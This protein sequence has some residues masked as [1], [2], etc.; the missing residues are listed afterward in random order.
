MKK[1]VTIFVILITMLFASACSSEEIK[2]NDEEAKEINLNKYVEVTFNGN[3]LAGY[4]SVS[5]DKEQFLLDNIDN[6]SFNKENEQVYKE[7]YGNVDK[8][9]A[10]EVLKYITVRLDKSN[11]L[12]NGDTVEIVWDINDEKIS[13]YF[14]FNYEFSSQT[15]TVAN[16]VDA[17]TFDPF[18]KIKLSYSGI[19]PYGEARVT[20]YEYGQ[21]G[22]YEITPN[23]NLKNGDT[24]KVSYLCED[25]S[26]MVQQFGTYPNCFEKEYIV[27]GLQSYVQSLEEVSSEQYEKL[28]ENALSH[29]WVLGYGQYKDATYLGNIFY[30]AKDEL[31]HGVHFLQWCGLPVGNAI[32]FVFERPK[33]IGYG[34]EVK[35]VYTVI[36]L[37]NLIINENGEL[38]YSRYDMWEYRTYDSKEDVKEALIGVFN[39][40]MHCSDDLN[41][42]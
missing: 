29:I 39:E 2:P 34:T 38:D 4:G 42:N 27:E 11:K 30:V 10:N 14:V 8:S 17:E 22:T 33:E 20:D 7:I 6:I 41:W 13:T 5:F 21:M 31:A 1:V 35:Q 37:E 26:A 3:N 19:A 23:G 24:I 15:F 16:L 36:A 32:C 28:V 9:P 25:K 12:T 40:I 18:E